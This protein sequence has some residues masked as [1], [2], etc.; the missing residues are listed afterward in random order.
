M[1]KRVVVD[2]FNINI[3][4][5]NFSSLQILNIFFYPEVSV[6]VTRA[7]AELTSELYKSKFTM[8]GFTWKVMKWGRIEWK[9]I[10]F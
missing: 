8:F 10:S 1:N 7:F 3:S 9:Y 6:Y 2:N 5:V 4:S